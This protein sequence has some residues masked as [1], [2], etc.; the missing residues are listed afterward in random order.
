VDANV[1]TCFNIAAQINFNY[2]LL[3]GKNKITPIGPDPTIRDKESHFGKIFG[4]NGLE[5]WCKE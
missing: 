4:E 3:Q 1:S 2:H 5:K